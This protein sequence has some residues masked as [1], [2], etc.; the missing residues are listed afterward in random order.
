MKGYRS[1]EHMALIKGPRAFTN[2]ERVAVKSPWFV[3]WVL[4][5]WVVIGLFASFVIYLVR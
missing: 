2:K 4:A 3:F 5:T 1:P